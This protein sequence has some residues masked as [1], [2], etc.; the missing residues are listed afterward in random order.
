MN[1]FFF[2]MFCCFQQVLYLLG[3]SSQQKLSLTAALLDL[4]ISYILFWYIRRVTICCKTFLFKISQKRP[5]MASFMAEEIPDIDN[6][7]III[8]YKFWSS[9]MS[10]ANFD[11]WKLYTNICSFIISREKSKKNYKIGLACSA[12]LNISYTC[13]RSLIQN[14]PSFATK[15]KPLWKLALGTYAKL[16]IN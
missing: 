6:Y 1:I 2:F 8:N 9:L 5:N 3:N 12:I 15:K 14:K 7:L 16:K 13:Y 4:R 10:Y 11:Q